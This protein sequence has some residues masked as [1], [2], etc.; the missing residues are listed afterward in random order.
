[1]RTTLPIEREES[2]EKPFYDAY[3]DN[4]ICS[5]GVAP[6]KR[7][8][9]GWNTPFYLLLRIEQSQAVFCLE[10]ILLPVAR[11]VKLQVNTCNAM[12]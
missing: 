10:L 9:F 4:I 1:M 7:S 2:F 11:I 5:R 6:D 12:H 8:Y 3:S